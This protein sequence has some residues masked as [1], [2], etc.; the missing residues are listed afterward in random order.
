MV[1]QLN[2][3]ILQSGIEGKFATFFLARLDPVTLRLDYSNAGHNPPLLL[4]ADG[5]IEWL[6]H[7]GLLLGIFE[8][9]RAS[10]SFLRLEAGDRLLLYT[11]GITE[12]ANP[13]REF[14]GEDRL[15]SALAATPP[16]TEAQE[17]VEAVLRSVHEFLDGEEPGDD[18]TIVAVRMPQPAQVALEIEVPAVTG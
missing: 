18:M 13:A 8:D 9:P 6:T 11:D 1:R 15:A 16:D 2:R 12:A 3:L 4:R 17:L 5:R 14:F 10:E 7:G